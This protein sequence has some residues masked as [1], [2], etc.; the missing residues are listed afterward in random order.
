MKDYL[1]LR[2][3]SHNVNGRFA[4]SVQ[5][6]AGH[7]LTAPA[8]DS[9]DGGCLRKEQHILPGCKIT[10]IWLANFKQD[11]T[12]I[13]GDVQLQGRAQQ[14]HLRFFIDS[15]KRH[16]KESGFFVCKKDTI[17]TFI[18]LKGH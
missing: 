15:N 9:G 11:V 10:A 4:A 1:C 3:S 13:R 12:E 6:S 14:N 17:N 8:A 18:S 7:L 16:Q 2:S 5:Y